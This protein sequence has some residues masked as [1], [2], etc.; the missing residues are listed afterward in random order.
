MKKLILLIILGTGSAQAAIVGSTSRYWY[1]STPYDTV[2]DNADVHGSYST[3]MSMT[4]FFV[5]DFLILSD[6]EGGNLT[7]FVL[8]YE[9]SDGRNTLTPSN[10]IIEQFFIEQY[11][12][13]PSSGFIAPWITIHGFDDA[14]NTGVVMSIA[15]YTSQSWT[16]VND[17]M[18]VLLAN[19]S[20][21]CLTGYGYSVPECDIFASADSAYIDYQYQSDS[22]SFIVP[23]PAA[24]WLFGSALVGLGW[25]RKVKA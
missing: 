25:F 19:S 21:I 10:S 17:S 4:A 3:D 14:T 2:I 8:A 24:A 22:W 16:Y 12:S 7:N 11:N 6:F 23:I 5:M 9:F 13:N 18:H 1:D 20:P 15:P